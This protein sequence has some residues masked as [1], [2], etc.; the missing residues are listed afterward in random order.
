MSKPKFMV[1]EGGYVRGKGRDKDMF[2]GEIGVCLNLRKNKR[3][4]ERQ[5]PLT[6]KILKEPK[7]RESNE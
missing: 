1:G 6:N 5:I 2:S 3:K 4:V 7:M